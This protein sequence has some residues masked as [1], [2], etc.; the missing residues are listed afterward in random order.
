MTVQQTD[1]FW[2]EGKKYVFL[3][4]DDI[5]ALFDPERYGLEPEY[6]ATNCWKGFILYLA[7]EGRKL[8]L[9]KLE[10]NTKEQVYPVINGVSAVTGDSGYHIYEDLDLPLEYTGTVV[11]G[12]EERKPMYR[13]GSFIGPQ[14]NKVT[15]DLIFDKGYLVSWN[16]SSGKYRG[17]LD[18]TEEE[19]DQLLKSDSSTD[20]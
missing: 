1:P 8:F 2:F 3:G 6:I 10:V 4:A 11:V 13:F 19:I 15:L 20:N 9:K 5:Y 12:E 18:L 17:I 16:N 14:Y 7:V